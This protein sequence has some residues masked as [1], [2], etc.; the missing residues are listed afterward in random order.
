[1]CDLCHIFKEV[2]L[3]IILNIYVVLWQTMGTR[4]YVSHIISIW[5]LLNWFGGWLK[6]LLLAK[7]GLGWKVWRSYGNNYWNKFVCFVVVHCL[8]SKGR[9]SHHKVTSVIIDPRFCSLLADYLLGLLID[10][11]GVGSSSLRS[12]GEPNYMVAHPRKCFSS[13]LSVFL[14]R[15]RDKGWHC[16]QKYDLNLKMW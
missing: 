4:F 15:I 12:V 3:V 16:N 7:M 1:V 8:Q 6:E 11:E 10:C 13:S 9:Q 5:T 14:P 2:S